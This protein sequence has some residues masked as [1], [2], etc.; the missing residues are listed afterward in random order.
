MKA[1]SNLTL[2]LSLLACLPTLAAE[3]PS[4]G[5]L[6]GPAMIVNGNTGPISQ[7]KTEDKRTLA[8]IFQGLQVDAHG[9]GKRSDATHLAL[10]IPLT[11]DHP[12]RLQAELRGS[13]TGTAGV[14]C[15]MSLQGPDGRTVLMARNAPQ[16]YLKTYLPVAAGD[17]DLKL[18]VG[19]RCTG[20]AG[21]SPVF[22]AAIDTL[23][24]T[25]APKRKH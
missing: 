5:V 6:T 2:T 24:V 10:Q 4:A 18:L 25:E 16:A 12:T 13:I 7:T 17:K 20:K 15:R 9:D 21:S 11:A 8:V 14:E 22:L 23:D 19:L 3:L 1:T